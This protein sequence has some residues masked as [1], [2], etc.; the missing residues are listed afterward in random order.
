M[1]KVTKKMVGEFLAETKGELNWCVCFLSIRK[2]VCVIWL[3][4]AM[5]L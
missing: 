4:V 1:K 2:R 5:S 3:T